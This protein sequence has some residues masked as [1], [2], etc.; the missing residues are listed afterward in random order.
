MKLYYAPSTCSLAPHIVLEEVGA[1]FN[2]VK[3]DLKSKIT[4]YGDDFFKVN[5]H[6]AVPALQLDNGEIL[7]EA[8]AI[9][10]YIADQFPQANLAPQNGTL[11]RA[12]LYERL[13]FLTSELH[14]S[15]A[16]LFT[17]GSENEKAKAV[18]K[19]ESK[20][21]FLDSILAE[22]SY[23]LGETFTVADAYLFVLGRWT[24]PTGIGLDKWPNIVE[25]SSR[26][27][28]RQSVQKAMKSEGLLS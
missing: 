25:F 23:L 2:L 10:Q 14:K 4:E 20:L 22:N 26:V 16:P 28:A 9:M 19:I 21:D 12:R 5:Q 11:E 24:A 13:N 8:V 15:F 3:V 17:N 7:T 18:T 27:E 1:D 6:G